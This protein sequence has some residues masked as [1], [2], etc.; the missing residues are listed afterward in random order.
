LYKSFN[1]LVHEA[2]GVVEGTVEDV[3]SRRIGQ[4]EIQTYVTLRDLSV[5]K[6]QYTGNRFTL[7]FEGGSVDGQV[8]HVHG[9]PTLR[10]GERVIAFVEGNGQQIVPLVGWEQGLFRVITPP[11]GGQRAISDSV[12]NRVFGIEGGQILKESRVSAEAE[13]VGQPT[14]GFGQTTRPGEIP[15]HLGSSNAGRSQLATQPGTPSE[16]GPTLATVA[17]SQLIT[18]EQF[19]ER[20]RQVAGQPTP[21]GAQRQPV[22]LS[23]VE[24]GAVPARR[25]RTDAP[26]P[27]EAASPPVQQQRVPEERGELPRRLESGGDRAPSSQ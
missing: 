1:D 4:S 23:T 2:D 21:A 13:V 17:P 11:G 9:S 19:V 18:P 16:A 27:R 22:P 6:G 14:S 25:D 24:V 15:I 3:V 7:M 20:I 10:Q 12:G 5:Y 8:V 26:P